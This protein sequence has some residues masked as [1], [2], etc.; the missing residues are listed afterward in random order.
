MRRHRPPR[1]FVD[2]P[3][4][5]GKYAISR[6]GT[7]YSYP[8]PRHK[9]G[10]IL[11]PKRSRTYVQIQLS[12]AKGIYKYEVV[13]RL[14]AETFIPNPDPVTY[15]QV[16]HKN[17]KKHD[18][19][20]RNLEW[21]TPSQNRK[22]AFDTGLQHFSRERLE[23]L[24]TPERREYWGKLGRQNAIA[25]MIPVLQLSVEGEVIQRFDSIRSAAR[26]CKIDETNICH[27]LKGRA[28]TAAGFIWVHADKLTQ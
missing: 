10:L 21:C 18:N 12:L 7:I 23:R 4:Y 6:S 19:R 3:G 15:I 17:G 8:K 27:V 1:G 13:H 22:H 14:L 25:R 20:L 16:N 11:K 26:A 2:I 28:R 24:R 9:D 5:E